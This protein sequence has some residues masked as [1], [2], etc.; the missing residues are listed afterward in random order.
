[1]F[2]CTAL[3]ALFE[4]TFGQEEAPIMV[5]QFIMTHEGMGVGVRVVPRLFCHDCFTEEVR[6]T[7]F[8]G[9][10]SDGDGGGGDG[11]NPTPFH[12]HGVDPAKSMFAT[13]AHPFA[14]GGIN[15]KTGK[16]ITGQL[17]TRTNHLLLPRI[18][19]R[20]RMDCFVP[21]SKRDEAIHQTGWTTQPIHGLLGDVV[22]G[23]RFLLTRALWMTTSLSVLL[24][25]VVGL[26]SLVGLGHQRAKQSSRSACCLTTPA[27]RD[28]NGRREVCITAASSFL[29]SVLLSFLAGWVGGG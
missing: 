10:S 1:M 28:V 20:S 7:T 14:K 24:R 29:P 3:F 26:Q 21:A 19:S 16:D 2:D 13:Y 25:P 5:L 11:S 18:C 9:G 4:H 27:L 22:G 17:E 23:S 15:F 8:G 12:A 6:G